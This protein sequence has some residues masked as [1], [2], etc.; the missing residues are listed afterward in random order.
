M[1]S[2]KVIGIG[3]SLPPGLAALFEEIA[4]DQRPR[5]EYSAAD[6]AHLLLAAAK[7]LAVEHTFKPGELVRPKASIED[8]YKP[9]PGGGGVFLKELSN[10]EI[11]ETYCRLG[12]SGSRHQ[13][14][15]LFTMF[16]CI[17]G[18]VQE[19]GDH[20]GQMVEILHRKAHLEPWFPFGQ[21]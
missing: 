15:V 7:A 13:D 4:N 9:F 5:V 20:A 17:I 12:Q 18:I 6:A 8:G 2:G 14:P 21:G 16:D 11:A 10:D 19:N 3:D 1:G